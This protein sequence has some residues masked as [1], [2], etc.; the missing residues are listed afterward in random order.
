MRSLLASTG[1]WLLIFALGILFGLTLPLSW[2]LRQ[3]GRGPLNVADW[4]YR[5][6][7]RL[8]ERAA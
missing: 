5:T 8:Q 6:I 4:S 7:V 2:L 3:L 1:R